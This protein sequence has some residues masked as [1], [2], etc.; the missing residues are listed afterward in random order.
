MFWF[1]LRKTLLVGKYFVIQMSLLVWIWISSAY[2]DGYASFDIKWVEIFYVTGQQRCRCFSPS[3]CHKFCV[4]FLADV[5]KTD[6][7][8][9][10][11]ILGWNFAALFLLNKA[12]RSL[13]L[14]LKRKN[15]YICYWKRIIRCFVGEIYLLSIQNLYSC[16]IH[17]FQ[18]L[19]V[20]YL[21]T[22]NG[23]S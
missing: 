18:W 14:V 12:P 8:W 20:C 6:L 9:I 1:S 11:L 3:F 22:E 2:L 4:A 16:S 15:N 13:S 5:M 10:I 21:R 17:Y 23:L 7:V 19:C